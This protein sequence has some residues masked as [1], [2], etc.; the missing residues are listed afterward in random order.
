[1]PDSTG[2]AREAN[3]KH[4]GRTGARTPSYENMII[5]FLTLNTLQARQDPQKGPFKTN[6]E[7]SVSSRRRMFAEKCHVN[8]LQDFEKKQIRTITIK[9]A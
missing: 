1:M 5:V 9:M 3:R 6:S 2:R 7:S 4:M 8:L